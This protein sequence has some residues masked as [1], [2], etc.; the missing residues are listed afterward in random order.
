MQS[1]TYT[2]VYNKLQMQKQNPHGL[3]T[4]L[5][6]TVIEKFVVLVWV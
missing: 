2:H 1:A 6:R 4:T 5:S 3:C